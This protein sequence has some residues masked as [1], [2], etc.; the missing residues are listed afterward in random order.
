MQYCGECGGPVDPTTSVCTYCRRT[1]VPPMFGRW[2]NSE[3]SMSPATNGSNEENKFQ[4]ADRLTTLGFFV[5]VGISI[6][7]IWYADTH[8][9]AV[10][11]KTR[12]SV[13]NQNRIF[14]ENWENDQRHWEI[15]GVSQG[16]DDYCKDKQAGQRYWPSIRTDLAVGDEVRYILDGEVNCQVII[17]QED[18]DREPINEAY[19]S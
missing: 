17:T 19:C 18:I 13:V 16:K 5:F 15:N 1:H 14:C 8:G 7:I 3:S 9:E 10:V 2:S 11:E 6:F 4:L 12:T